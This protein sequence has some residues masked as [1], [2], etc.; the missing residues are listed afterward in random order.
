MKPRS[1]RLPVLLLFG[2]ICLL[3]ALGWFVSEL[4]SFTQR[5]SLL[6]SG[7]TIAGVP[8]G[9][10]RLSEANARVEQAYAGAVTLYY[11]DYPINI[12]PDTLGFRLNLPTML[13][14]ATAS[15]EREGGFWQRFSDYLLGRDTDERINIE[16]IADYQ[17]SALRAQLEQIARVFDRPSENAGYDLQTFTAYAGET[18][19]E[20]DVERA[21]AMV[22]TALRSATQRFV[23]LPVTGGKFAEPTLETLREL[24]IS[25]LDAKGFIYDGQNSVASV[26]IMDLKTGEEISI[27]SDVAFTAASTIK[28]PILIDYFKVLEGEVSQDNAWLMANS[29]LCSANSTSNLIMSDIIGRGDLFRGIADVTQTAQR[30]GAK[31]TFITAPF[32]DG[33]PNQVLG[34]IATPKTSPNPNYNTKPDPFNQTT[35]EDLGTLF[36]M[37]YDCA[38]YNSGLLTAYPN[39]EFTPRECRQ[40]LE[41][42]SGLELRR[43][44]EGGVPEGTRISY[45]NGWVG[46]VTGVSGIVFPPNGRDYVISVFLWEDTG[47]RGFQDYIRLWPLI[48]DISRATWNHFV[49]EQALLAPRADLPATAQECFRIDANGNRVGVYLPPYGQVNLDN[50]NGWRSGQ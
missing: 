12:S 41:L 38:Y 20:L 3:I 47:A 8:V 34:S 10:L 28:V 45:K 37:I 25:Y 42:M 22:D 46:E 31:N 43:L 33:S 39:G 2:L 18:G 15:A 16:L 6:P 7:L 23:D 9:N 30:L 32:I 50:I 35:A 44:L 5:E 14:E 27:L 24:I 17:Q 19:Y 40:M 4:V 21:M 26:F 1:R 49:P 29:I 36:S 13:A 11:R 48:E